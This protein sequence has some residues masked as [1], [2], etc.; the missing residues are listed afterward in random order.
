MKLTITN[1]TSS[2]I[3]K[4]ELTDYLFDFLPNIEY[5]F[6]QEVSNKFYFS[7]FIVIND[8]DILLCDCGISS[9]IRITPDRFIM[10]MKILHSLNETALIIN[11]NDKYELEEIKKYV[12]D[13]NIN[14]C[15]EKYNMNNFF[16]ELLLLYCDNN[17]Y[18]ITKWLYN[19]FY[20]KFEIIDFK[21]FIRKNKLQKIL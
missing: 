14:I 10:N 16:S 15:K 2:I 6:I 12:I 5:K 4:N 1:D 13:N 19:T 18:P 11:V 9:G 3:D 17:I 7:K 20:N 21:M 8:D